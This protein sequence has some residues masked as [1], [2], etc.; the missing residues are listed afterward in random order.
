M[1]VR[2]S[3]RGAGPSKALVVVI[4]ISLTL[5]LGVMAGAVAK[6]L[7]GTSTTQAQ[8]IKAQTGRAQVYPA[9]HSG[10]QMADET[11]AAPALAGARSANGH[12]AREEAIAATTTTLVGARSANGRGDKE[13]SIP[14]S[15]TLVGAR[16]ANG[17]GARP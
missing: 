13:D 12:G 11:A 7:S 2:E 1:E 6:N 9:K 14:T 15:S 5:G 17:H 4:A 16:S 10:L 8:P 3:L